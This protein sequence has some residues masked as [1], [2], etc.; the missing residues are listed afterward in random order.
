MT[1]VAAGAALLVPALARQ[2]LNAVPTPIYN[3]RD[4]RQ[5]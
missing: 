5:Q 1:V 2:Y 4:A 3:L